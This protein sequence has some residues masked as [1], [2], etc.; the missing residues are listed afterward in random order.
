MKKSAL[1][2]HKEGS[3]ERIVAHAVWQRS[4]GRNPSMSFVGERNPLKAL[5]LANSIL[6]VAQH[7][8]LV[9]L[10]GSVVVGHKSYED[11]TDS[12]IKVAVRRIIRSS[13][14]EDEVHR[15][16]RDELSYPY[17]VALHTTVPEDATGKE[18]RE[19][20]R[21]LGGLIMANGAMT[22]AMMHGHDGVISL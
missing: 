17:S 7:T 3:A 9:D 20:V 18:A 5:A 16:V 10:I 13:S 4:R 21:G 6:H 19:L 12:E 1:S 11:M 22:M 14:S 15:R 2:Q 8:A